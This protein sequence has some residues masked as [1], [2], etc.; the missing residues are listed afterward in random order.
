MNSATGLLWWGG[1][2]SKR[3]LPPGRRTG[4][5]PIGRRV[6]L[7]VAL[8]LEAGF[9]L[10][11]LALAISLVAVLAMVFLA[12]LA[13]TFGLLTLL[14]AIARPMSRFTAV[15][16]RA[17]AHTAPSAILV[18]ATLAFAVALFPDFQGGPPPWGQRHSANSF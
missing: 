3:P 13:T 17:L 4:P 8:F 15:A 1:R 7:L 6:P 9:I 2:R 5:N 11:V 12:V 18:L 14:R 16:A 10:A